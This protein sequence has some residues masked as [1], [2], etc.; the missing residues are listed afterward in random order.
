MFVSISAYRIM[1]ISILLGMQL[2]VEKI[3]MEDKVMD[4]NKVQ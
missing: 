2:R 1:V 3:F 4:L